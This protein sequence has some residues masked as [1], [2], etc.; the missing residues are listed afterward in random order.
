MFEAFGVRAALWSARPG[1]PSA[2]AIWEDAL[3]ELLFAASWAPA[4]PCVA[5]LLGD[6][7][8]VGAGGVFL[9][10][11]V[12]GFDA[13]ERPEALDAPTLHAWS[14]RALAVRFDEPA[15]GGASRVLVGARDV[16]GVFAH[17]PGSRGR[18][19]AALAATYLTW[20][21]LP[22]RLLWVADV[23]ADALGCW[24]R[25]ASGEL[26][27]EP[28]TTLARAASVAPAREEE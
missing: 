18:P 14:K 19:D 23:G 27:T 25:V 21:N 17:A 4:R 24:T 8:A 6:S 22:G 7:E 3:D 12:S 20:H 28:L 1:A 9:T 26:A 5:L 16:L 15:E 2:L 13:L 10:R 11:V